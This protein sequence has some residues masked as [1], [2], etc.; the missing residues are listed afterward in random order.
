MSSPSPVVSS[1]G[2]IVPFLR[3]VAV[4]ALLSVAFVG[5]A[6]A[7]MKWSAYNGA[8]G[9]L[10]SGTTFEGAATFDAATNSYTFTI[11]A[12]TNVTLVT[13][14]FLPVDLTKPASG[15]VTQT[16]SFQMRTSDGGLG[17]V[18]RYR[19]FGLFNAPAGSTP[20]A[21]S[22]QATT[23]TGL[24]MTGYSNGTT[25]YQSKPSGA[26]NASGLTFASPADYRLASSNISQ[27]AAGFGLGTGRGTGVGVMAD[28]T[29]YDVTFRVRGNAAGTTQLGSAA[30]TAG[31]GTVWADTATNGAAFLQTVYSS[32]TNNGL[33]CP[34]SFNEFAFYFENPSAQPVTLVLANLRGYTSGG[35]AFVLGPAYFTTQ[36]LESVTAAA[37]GSFSLSAVP[38]AASVA[39]GPTTTYQWQYSTDGASYADINAA[40]NSSA[41]TTTLS[42]SNV[43]SSHAGKYRLKVTTS[44]T[45]GVSGAQSVVSYS[46]VSTVSVSSVALAPSISV[47]PANTSVLVGANAT[48][49]VTVG[50]STPLSY[51]WS[52]SLDGGA[53]YSD[54]ANSNAPTYT[55]TNAQLED[56]GLYRV[57]VSNSEGTVTSSAATLSVNQG[58]VIS[59]Q[60]TGGTIA[61]GDAL[62]LSVLATGTPT[63]TY[64]WY[65]NGTSIPGATGSSYQIASATGAHTGNYTVVVTNS[66]S[67]VT[68][69]VA[70][71]AVLSPSMARVATTPSA[72]GS[73]LNPDVRLSITFN[74][75]PTAGVSG[76]IRIYDAAT[77][78]VV[79]SIDLVAATALRDSLRASSTLSTQ[80]LPVAKKPIGSIATDFNYYPLT[81]S[82]NTVT[83]HPRNGVLTYGKTYYVRIDPGAIVSSSGTS[84]AG[85]NDST[86]WR[87]S[88]KASGP[89]SGATELTVA[90]DGSGDFDTVQAAFDFVPAANTTPTTIRI[91]RGT[92]FEQVAFQA[93]HFLT[94]VGEDVDAT[95]IIYPNN[96]TFNNVSGVYHRSTFIAQSVRNFVIANLSIT[97]STPQNGSQ[98]EALIINGTSAT[99]GKNIVTNCKFFSY[100]DTVQF[101]KQTYVSD[102]TII[103]DVDFMWGDGPAYFLNCDIRILRTGGYFT[104]VRNGSSNHGYV[105]VGCR[106]TAP[107]GITG[108]YFGRID[109]TSANFPYSEVVV[110]DSVIGDAANN[111]LL[112]TSTGVSGSN[113]L[114]GWWLLNNVTTAGSAP[115]VRNWDFNNVDATGAALTNPNSDTFTT[116]PTDTA[117]LAN[118]RDATWVLNTSIAGVVNG[119]WTPALAPILVQSPVAQSVNAGGSVTL[120]AFAVGVPAVSY[121]W[122]KNGAVIQGATGRTLVLS[123]ADANT[124]GGYTV[125]VTNSAGNAVS[126]L[127][128]VSV[129][130]LVVAPTIVTPPADTEIAEGGTGTLSVIASGT[131]PL[132]YQW[133]K[134]DSLLAGATA[135]TLTISNATFADAGS[136]KVAVSNSAGSVTSTPAVVTVKGVAAIQPDG[137]SADVT[138]GA[139]GATVT[140]STAAALKT[141]AEN[142]TTPFTIIVSGTIDLG[143]NGRIK[144]Q[145]N[146]TLRGATTA[147][148]ILG[149]I[150]IS[151]AT[152]VIVSN[153]N[154]SA[155]TG[156][157]SDNDGVTIANSTRVLVTK[158]TIYN[159]TDGNLDVINGSDLVTVS[160]CKFY[161]TRDNGHNFSNLVGSSDTDVGSGDGLTNYR[162]SWHHNWWTGM[163]KQRM[164]ACRFGSSHM[165]NNYWD[166]AGNDYCTETRNI[167]S[168]FSE[169]N[170][171]SN[172]KN[173]LARRDALVTDVGLLMT[174]GNVFDS[175][176]GTQ[177]TG[178]DVVFTPPYS[179]AYSPAASVP[180]IVM[181]GAGNVT[182][183]IPAAYTASITG[184]AS[185]VGAGGSVTLSAA[186]AGFVPVSY[187]WR[188]R[189]APISGATSSSLTVN[190]VQAAQAGDYTVVL[191][192][193]DGRFVVSRPFT[194]SLLPPLEAWRQTY[195]GTTASTGNAAD[196][197][198]PDGD[199]V[200]NILEYALGTNPTTPASAAAPVGELSGGNYVV[201]YTRPTST[202]DVT[203]T[204]QQS[205]DL[206]TWTNVASAVE[207]SNSATAT[208]AVSVSA[209]LPRQF[210]RLV[211]G[212]GVTTPIGY[213]NLAIA[214]GGATST[215]GIPLDEPQ[216]PS[217]GIRAGRIDAL[218]ATSLTAAAGGWTDGALASASAP[219][220]VRFTSGAAAGRTLAVSANTATTLTF[221][222]VS[223]TTLGVVA[224]DAFEL[225]AV[226]TLN[227]FFGAGT[228]AGGTAATTA[229]AVRIY[230]SAWVSYYYSTSLGYWRLASGPTTNYG[231][232]TLRTQSGL[233]VLRRGAA[234]NLTVTGRVLSTPYRVPVANA[235]G[236]LLNLGYPMDTTLAGLSLQSRISGWRS[237]TT[238]T[239]ADMVSLYDGS[240]WVSYVYNGSY[241]QHLTTGVNSNA[242]AIPAGSAVLISR[243]GSTSGT[244]DFVQ[245]RPY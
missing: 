18:N 214:G 78:A 47:P 179:Y 158:C 53:N 37:G 39:S 93:K 124:P 36:P 225:V 245:S 205:T 121:Q 59:A 135:A 223:L 139:A 69:S 208:H 169:Y 108:T 164:I 56:A 73:G 107:A 13:T 67:S 68:S 42:I 17:A 35:T 218:T 219:W 152:N 190:N 49:S 189:N 176:T 99:I 171:Y 9:A 130:G 44:A 32:A 224:G 132:A 200:A 216:G 21:T 101:N 27:S 94:V 202:T 210:F 20:N 40:T 244:T 229:D 71:V 65:R 95:T 41:A 182:T 136:Y 72:G 181:A 89:A 83:I 96:N 64:Q 58:P 177:A 162:I 227:T 88:T 161:Y 52:R 243:P 228:L 143:A 155:D 120:S 129:L 87:F 235:G 50:G 126:A 75:A 193:S 98:A 211:V 233:Q 118:Y 14:N 60:P 114:A 131:A 133:F 22:N 2:V 137:Y 10:L 28:N 86:T 159:C 79:D 141:Y 240:S 187:A 106:F 25:T 170:V 175:C 55:L 234:M 220:S 80:L 149:T 146:K 102:S 185:A 117:T 33:T 138:G 222:G 226:D 199:G 24:W 111:A 198:D 236:T 3:A 151:N 31:A 239:T 237:G 51:V 119:S 77:D 231:N 213:M 26:P 30:T 212:A 12:G 116:M 38:V 74:E 230:S 66:I 16:V 191:G 142:T 90:A 174:L 76:L 128:D 147:S 11:P 173:P 63:P 127:A 48:F 156:N 197:A 19:N 5:A 62:T 103:G 206:L 82:G 153:L 232:V 209:T 194:L 54:I 109:P 84:F 195:F 57:T 160:W 110:L 112:N 186:P 85:L 150:N 207:S 104:Q 7:Q 163:A 123:N 113:Y 178:S 201:R 168:I 92:Y 43:S 1:R 4:L 167:A 203:Y 180:A 134:G 196:L 45:G 29:W 91:K 221:S 23:H 188:F 154:I 61:V 204:V 140:V 100:Q 215:F 97:N 184:S 15:N 148:T 166:C 145:S 241:W 105:F 172:V 238:S 81:I 242:I 115:N 34:V 192:L 46:G 144:L 183:A 217:S 122:R 8:T 70:S 157:P 6:R 125:E 165:Y